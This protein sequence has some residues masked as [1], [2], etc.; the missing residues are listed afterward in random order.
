MRTALLALFV[1]SLSTLAL[2]DSSV[3][4]PQQATTTAAPI[5]QDSPEKKIVCHNQI[6]EGEATRIVQCGTQ[7][8][9][10]RTR[11]HTAK[12]LRDIQIRSYA[13]SRR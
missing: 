1:S 4:G 6:H 5:P 8:A 7:Q 12:A 9:W 10:E 3:P 2:A 13:G 11:Q